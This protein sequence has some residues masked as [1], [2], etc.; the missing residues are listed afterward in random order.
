MIYGKPVLLCASDK[1]KKEYEMTD[2]KTIE[3]GYSDS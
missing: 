1:T 2:S 3:G